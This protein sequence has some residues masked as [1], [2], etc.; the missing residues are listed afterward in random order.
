MHGGYKRVVSYGKRRKSTRKPSPPPVYDI[1]TYATGYGRP[2]N[3]VAP[4]VGGS[5][6][7]VKPSRRP[8]GKK[9][10]RN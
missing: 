5:R 3:Y 10:L 2:G 4:V 1:P 9:Q 6:P 7:F 8:T